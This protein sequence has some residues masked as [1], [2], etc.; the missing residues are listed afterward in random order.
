MNDSRSGPSGSRTGSLDHSSLD[1]HHSS[2]IQREL[3]KKKKSISINS[4]VGKSSDCIQ[5]L[6]TG[7][8]SA[9]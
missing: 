5:I 3:K 4:R 2:E 8:A 6:F 7:K 1:H 9:V